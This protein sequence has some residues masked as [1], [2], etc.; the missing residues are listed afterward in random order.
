MTE[1]FAAA[2]DAFMSNMKPAMARTPAGSRLGR[3]EEVAFAV[4]FLCE[5]RA[6]WVNGA[7]VPVCG[8][9]YVG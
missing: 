7:H 1:G 3:P 5:E 8:G 2:G 9:L 6:G 4:A